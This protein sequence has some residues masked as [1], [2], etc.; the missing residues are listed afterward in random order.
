MAVRKI[1][2]ET[3]H[4]E[5]PV[6]IDQTVIPIHVAV[7]RACWTSIEACNAILVRARVFLSSPGASSKGLILP[8]EGRAFGERDKTAARIL[9]VWMFKRER[10]K[11]KNASINFSSDVQFRWSCNSF[12]FETHLFLTLSNSHNGIFYF[13]DTNV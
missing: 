5:I 7:F 4:L 13:R 10:K 1:V 6:T 8:R 11:K 2:Q 12:Y 3:R 9:V